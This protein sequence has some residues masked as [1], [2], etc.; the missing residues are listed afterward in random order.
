MPGPR[1]TV[2]SVS[3][4]AFL[5][6]CLS[7]FLI[8][9]PS[10][11]RAEDYPWYLLTPANDSRDPDMCD[12]DD[13]SSRDMISVINQNEPLLH[14]S[15][16]WR[17]TSIANLLSIQAP[18]C[19]FHF[20]AVRPAGFTPAEKSILT[21]YLKRGGFILFFIDAYPYT[22]DQFW[23]V[24]EWPV[25]DFIKLDLPAADP[26]FTVA[27]VTDADPIFNV[28]Y[29]TETADGIRQELR[30]NPNTPNRTVLYYKGRLC[31]FVMGKYGY[32]DEDTNTWIPYTRPFPQSFSMVFKSYQL[33]VNLYIYSILR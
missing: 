12:E 1:H 22:Q 8:S 15:L 4:R 24:K 18:F 21:E 29:K 5:L 13:A 6:C 7:L 16:V 3:R 19:E 23:A 20:D 27:K 31:C 28:H 33:I 2:E 11:A 14:N 25:I 10:P 17:K 9:L 26:D 32:Y 30:D